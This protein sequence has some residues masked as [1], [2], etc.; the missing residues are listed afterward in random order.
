MDVGCTY[1]CQTH[2]TTSGGGGLVGYTD[3]DNVERTWPSTI[4]EDVGAPFGLAVPHR[5][6]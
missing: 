4:Q 2:S 3:V 5:L 1:R 6:E